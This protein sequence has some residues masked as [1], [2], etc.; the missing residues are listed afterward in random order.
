MAATFFALSLV[1]CPCPGMTAEEAETSHCA[2]AQTDGP[3]WSVG[4][5]GCACLCMTRPEATPPTLEASRGTVTAPAVSAAWPL[6]SIAVML[7][8]GLV[9]VRTPA[10]PPPAPPLVQRI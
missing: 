10:P 1:P 2:G 7:D 8:P 4:E 6:R 3:S 5:S 9:S